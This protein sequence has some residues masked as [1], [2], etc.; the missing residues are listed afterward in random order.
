MAID[1]NIQ[2][3]LSNA[4]D[5]FTLSAHSR[6]FPLESFDSGEAELF[7]TQ[8]E[9]LVA[10]LDSSIFSTLVQQRQ[11]TIARAAALA[12]HDLEAKNFGGI[13]AADNEFGFSLLRPGH[14]RRYTGEDQA[15]GNLSSGNI[16]NDWYF[17]PSGTGWRDWIGDGTNNMAVDENQVVVI[18]GFADQARMPTE[19]SG[20][21]VQNFGRNMDMLPRDLN[22][23]RNQDNENEVQVVQTQTLI[24]QEGDEIYARLRF[25]RQVERQPRFFGFTFGRGR[26]LN[27]EDYQESDYSALP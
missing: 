7:E 3:T 8:L 14:I 10:D 15:H 1:L 20:I 26:Y 22:E 19:I 17:E 4:S 6:P 16:V 5:Q 9:D 2:R 11:D 21:N 24:G 18:L 27:Q 25:D 13:N 23:M 12:K